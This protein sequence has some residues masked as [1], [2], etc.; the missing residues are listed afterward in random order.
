MRGKVLFFSEEKGFGKI[1]DSEKN[2][3]FIYINKIKN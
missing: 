2:E 1:I 3:Y